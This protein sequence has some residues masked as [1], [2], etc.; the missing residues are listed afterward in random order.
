MSSELHLVLQELVVAPS[1][2]WTPEGH[3]WTAV[4][5]AA[6]Y[7]Y[8]LGDDEAHETKAGE[9]VI[10][11]PGAKVTFRASQL[12]ELKLE[13]FTVEPHLLDGL[14][15][16]MEWH[17]LESISARNTQRVFRYAANDS[18]AQKFARLAT[19]SQRD[20]LPVRLAFLQLWASCLT[21]LLPAFTQAGAG[22]KKLRLRFRQFFGHL[23]EKELAASSLTDM[24]AELNCS[25]RH[26]SRMFR[27]EFGV[28]LRD[29]QNELRLQRACRLLQ[30]FKAKISSVAFECGYRHL[31]LFNLMFKKRFGLSP[32]QWRRQK[33]DAKGSSS[34]EHAEITRAGSHRPLKQIAKDIVAPPASWAGRRSD[35]DRPIGKPEPLTL[36][37]DKAHQ[38]SPD[39]KI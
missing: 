7:G 31:G 32:S 25:E 39:G 17:Q 33:L 28:S 4:R 13:F 27:E 9:A 37:A 5:V 19:L 23:S 24:A 29:C 16:V 8:C 6:G 22:R 34:F 3:A 30:D 35:C 12:G 20:A 18:L 15:T 26:F 21:N 38:A 10:V 11:G 1:D 36:A 14:F 2:E